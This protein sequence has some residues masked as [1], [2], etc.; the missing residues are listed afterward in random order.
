VGRGGEGTGQDRVRMAWPVCAAG[1]TTGVRCMSGVRWLG[2]APASDSSKWSIRNGAPSFFSSGVSAF[3]C[4][5]VMAQW[6]RAISAN[7]PKRKLAS[8]NGAWAIRYR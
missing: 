1:D 7:G 3:L 6:E 5:R 2:A 4:G 8:A